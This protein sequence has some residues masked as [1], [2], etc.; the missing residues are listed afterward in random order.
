[1][2]NRFEKLQELFKDEI[3]AQKM[4]TSTVE[5]AAALLKEQHD[6]EFTV[7]ELNDVAAGIR[8][9]LADE[10]TDELSQDMLEQVV[11]GGKSG[12]YYTG[13]YIG[14]GV[15]VAAAGVGIA[16]GLVALGVISW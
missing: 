9:G 2:D 6:L 15:K 1:M 16:A 4:L 10:S 14:K 7:D 3:F 5:E 12:A 11:G 13:Y 8:A